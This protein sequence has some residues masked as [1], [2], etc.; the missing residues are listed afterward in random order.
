[1][2]LYEIT[3]GSYSD[4]QHM[5]WW[6]PDDDAQGEC[7]VLDAVREACPWDRDSD[8]RDGTWGLFWD[9]E[10]YGKKFIAALARMGWTPAEVS[11]VCIDDVPPSAAEKGEA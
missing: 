4:R 8:F 3:R 5:I 7:E 9:E 2:R 1:M 10:E 11:G 6:G